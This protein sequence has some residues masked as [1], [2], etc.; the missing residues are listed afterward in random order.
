MTD[1]DI[2]PLDQPCP[3][4]DYRSCIVDGCRPHHLVTIPGV[5]VKPTRIVACMWCGGDSSPGRGQCAPCDALLNAI[6]A[7]PRAGILAIIQS[8]TEA[9]D[10]QNETPS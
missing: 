9:A 2:E 3:H 4:G 10:L 7:A 1:D 8:W 5:L 6:H